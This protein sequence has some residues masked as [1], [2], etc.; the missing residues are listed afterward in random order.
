MVLWFHV[1]VS[2][3]HM[4][5]LT[6]LPVIVPCFTM[7][8][9]VNTTKR[10]QYECSQVALPNQ[11]RC[12]MGLS[13][14]L[15]RRECLRWRLSPFAFRHLLTYPTSSPFNLLV[16]NLPTDYA[17]HNNLPGFSVS[18]VVFLSPFSLPPSLSSWPVFHPTSFDSEANSK[19]TC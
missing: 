12:A 5:S 3:F 14:N 8:Y 9:T 4:S 16:E 11:P 17:N 2:R 13:S 1:R 19:F 18:E 7:S 15:T 10:T 6:G